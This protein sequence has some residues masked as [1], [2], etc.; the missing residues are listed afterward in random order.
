MVT[1]YPKVVFKQGTGGTGNFAIEFNARA[2]GVGEQ[3][4]DALDNIPEYTISAPGTSD[5]IWEEDIWQA[6]DGL[7]LVAGD[8]VG[9][10]VQRDSDDALDTFNGDLD[11]VGIIIKYN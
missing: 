6:F 8:S 10:Q 2:G 9:L 1:G 4:S 5:E 7:G 11:V 3:M